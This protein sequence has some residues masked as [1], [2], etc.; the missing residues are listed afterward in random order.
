MS[1]NGILSSALTS[2]QTNTA[3][4]RV[5]SN[6]VANLNTQGYARRVVN[7]QALTVGGQLA[8]VDIGDIQRV[9]DQFLAQET[10]SASA[11]SAQYGAQNDVFKQLNGLLGQPGDGS[12]LTRKL[13]NIFAALGTAAMSPSS[14]ASS[15]GALN[16]FGDLASTISNLSDSLSTLQG[17]VDQQVTSSIGS[18]NSLIQQIYHLNQQV[19]TANAAGDT[20]SGLLDER[21]LAVQNLSQLIGVRTATKANGEITV[22]TQDGVNLVGDTYAKLSYAGGAT[23]GTYGSIAI[24]NIDPVT[25]AATGPS[26]SFDA[27]LSSG[28]I[29]GLIDMRDGALSDL[30]QELGAF[31]Q[32]TANAFNAQH[33]A[34]AAFPPP[35][36]LDGRATGL[37]SS[38]ALNFTG[39]TTIAVAD[40]NGDMV[41]RIDVD[42]GAGKLSVDG[43]ASI[44]F[45]GTIGGFVSAL[46]SALGAN[47][48][49]S[50]ANGA[51]SLSA[52]TGNGVVIQDNAN[53]P[54]SRGGAGFSQFF[55][56]NDLFRT[57]SPSILATG[58]SASDAGGFAAGGTMAF[59]LKEANGAIT[60]QANITLASGMS[61]GDI[62]TAMN[63]AFGGAASFSLDS[64]GKL[65]MSPANGRLDVTQ[66]TTARGTTGMSFT[67]L[68]GLGVTQASAPATNFS[69]N[70]AITAAP[71]LL[72][73]GQP[74]ISATSVA[75]DTIVSHGDSRG[76]L[77]LQ[78]LSGIRQSFAAIGGLGA[79]A[80]TLNEFAGSFY[81]DVSTRSQAAASANTSQSDRLQEAQ[82]RQSSD[83]GVNLDEEL[84]NMMMYQQAYGAGARILTT[85]QQLY[86]TL[87]Q[88]A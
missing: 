66:D 43:G 47:G 74:S 27:H 62:V 52:K 54:S 85:V 36:E 19:N 1:L 3:A 31:A 39:K 14:S 21:D 51:L 25:G 23:N 26:Q 40:S 6:N 59:T 15:Q 64:S 82:A 55:G 65:S 70:P 75:G 88:V 71:Q 18:V 67:Q 84:S 72:A 77:A 32:Q 76:I 56:L 42:F 30:K 33:N 45:G 58:L 34:N 83:S 16:A 68:F 46:N 35:S 9:A 86:D 61:I 81:Q 69:V 50:F 2:L 20:S 13:D 29:K 7:E 5:V 24:D 80:A 41:S 63:T 12:A 8:G 53:T 49:A 37:L 17:Q 28:K 60:K 38:D 48:S 44:G 22:M 4:L 73:F 10:L 78:N 87:L 11:G 79:Q 57:S